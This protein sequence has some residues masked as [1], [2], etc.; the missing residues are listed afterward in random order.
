MANAM[1]PPQAPQFTPP[2]AMPPPQLRRRNSSTLSIEHG[3]FE[4]LKQYF[5]PEPEELV[6][7]SL[8]TPDPIPHVGQKHRHSDEATLNGLPALSPMRPEGQEEEDDAG[9]KRRRKIGWTN[10]EDLT[11]LAAVRR[12][13]TQWQRIADN[14]PGRTADAVRNRWHRLQRNHALSDTDEGRSALDGLLVASGVDVDW[15]PPELAGDGPAAAT[16]NGGAEPCIRGSDHGRQMWSPEEDQIIRDGVARF[17]CKWR[18]IASLLSGRT[19]SSVR[20]RWMRLCRENQS[21]RESSARN[22]ITEP[23]PLSPLTATA[24]PMQQQ[25]PEQT[26]AA[27]APVQPALMRQNSSAL[28]RQS[29]QEM[30]L[31]ELSMS[32]KSSLEV[33][34][35]PLGLEAPTMVLDLDS[36]AEAVSNCVAGTDVDGLQNP[37][38]DMPRFEA[39]EAPLFHSA[40]PS[41]VKQASSASVKQQE[42]E[43][44]WAP[45]N[46]RLASAALAVGA[47]VTVASTVAMGGARGGATA[48][49]GGEA[50]MRLRPCIWS[51]GDAHVGLCNMWLCMRLIA[52]RLE[53]T[54][55]DGHVVTWAQAMVQDQVRINAVW[56]YVLT[57]ALRRGVGCGAWAES[58]KAVLV[59][60]RQ[61]ERVPR[62]VSFA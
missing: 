37:A 25:Q 53:W 4:W 39:F 1:P 11:I 43:V 59:A 7:A 58:M 44:H 3:D 30:I 54:W 16:G 8:P 56:R 45:L 57:S 24:T 38:S 18:Q 5:K 47:V 33:E 41:R 35:L 52:R 62:M 27:S 48:H 17:G 34:K 61:R 15:C 51:H 40:P 13:G 42:A 36:F 14:L 19:D 32:L 12:V 28:M 29:S 9:F 50:T 23:E 60:R 10:T 26:G 6:A 2:F 55:L 20:N 21:V 31:D 46:L 49:L 22:S